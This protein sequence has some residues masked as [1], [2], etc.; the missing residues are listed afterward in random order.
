MIKNVLGTKLKV[1]SL[2][3]VTGF[4]RDGKCDTCAEDVGLHTV[5]AEL[6]LEFLEFGRDRGNDLMTPRPEFGFAG[7]RPGDKWCICLGRWIEAFNENQAIAPK[8]ALEATHHSVLE[9]VPLE[10]LK[11][12][13]LDSPGKPPVY[14]N[15]HNGHH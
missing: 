15:G 1:C 11:K 13:A 4:F 5:C 6:T 3:P 10:V 9:H 8:I 2:D 12:Y 7:L 14:T